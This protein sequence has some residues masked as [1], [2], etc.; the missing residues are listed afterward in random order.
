MAAQ[1]GGRGSAGA[2]GRRLRGGPGDVPAAGVRG[3]HRARAGG[4]WQ[5]N[6]G[7]GTTT[8][9]SSGN[10]HTGTLGS[11]VTWAAPGAGAHSITANDTLSTAAVTVTGPVVN[12]TASYTASAWVYLNSV[13]G[14][15]QT[16][17]SITGTATP[18]ASTVSGFYLQ[19]VPGGSDDFAL[20]MRG[21]DA[22]GSAVTQAVGPSNV[23]IH[24]WYHIVGVYNSVAKT[25]A[26]YI[27]G[28]LQQTTSFTTAWQATG[29]TMIGQAYYGAPVDWFNGRIDD[30]ALYAS[31]LTAAQ[32]AALNQPTISAG[33]SHTCEIISGN[34][35]CWGAGGSGQLGNNGTTSSSVPVLVQ[36]RVQAR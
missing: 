32:V 9:D 2:G 12:T 11:G 27:N 15:N 10:G 5:F 25:I 28:A 6:E 20:T 18:T 1:R 19:F 23:V 8:A 35:Y 22:T 36:A 3:R 21:A 16:F 30:V 33:Y 13:G 31:A 34:A 14:T 4:Q 29:N 24:T 17:V 7:S 26:L